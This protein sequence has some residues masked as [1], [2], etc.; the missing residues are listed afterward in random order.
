MIKINE[1]DKR[2]SDLLIIDGRMSCPEIAR[3]IGNISE[4]SVRYRIDRLVKNGVIAIRASV[5]ASKVGFPVVGDV[6]LEV[7][8]GLVREIADKLAG[9]EMISYL[10]C[11]TGDEEISL[12]IYARDH[13]EIYTLVTYEISKIPGVRKTHIS[14]VP[15]VVKDDINWPIPTSCVTQADPE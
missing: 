2:I 13:K 7:E 14:F 4:R 12:Q 11:S 5:D 10:A 15:F 6:Y 3:R 1:I 8:P 9:F